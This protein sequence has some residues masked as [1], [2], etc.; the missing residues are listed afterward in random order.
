MEKKQRLLI[1]SLLLS[2]LAF[3][4]LYLGFVSA[5]KVLWPP[6]VTGA[7]FLL[8]AWQFYMQRQES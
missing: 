6:V 3:V 5:I 2:V 1:A 7:G 4:M 8:I